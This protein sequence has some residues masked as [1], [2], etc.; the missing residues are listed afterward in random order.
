LTDRQQ[1]LKDA[2]ILPGLSWLMHHGLKKETTELKKREWPSTSWLKK[3]F[4]KHS[5]T[6]FTAV[7][8]EV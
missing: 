3:M 6:P 1:S 5:T 7:V 8:S 4:L 2:L